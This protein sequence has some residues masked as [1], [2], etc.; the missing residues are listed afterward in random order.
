LLAA[1]N[2]APQTMTVTAA[3]DANTV[4]SKLTFMTRFFIVVP[5]A[6][7]PMCR[8]FARVMYRTERA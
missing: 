8:A 3:R 4:R 1:L 6:D 7:W 5:P 2:S